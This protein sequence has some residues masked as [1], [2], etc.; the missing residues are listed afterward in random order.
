MF[1][2]MVSGTPSSGESGRP[3]RQRDSE[4]LRLLE[5]RVA[6]HAVHGV[7][8]R[9]PRVDSL[10]QRA[11]DL[12][13]R[14]LAARVGRGELRG[15]ALVNGGHCNSIYTRRRM[16]R[17][18]VLVLLVLCAA[19][20]RAADIRLWHSMNGTRG[21]EFDKLVARFNASQAQFRVVATYKG[22]FD[23]AAVEAVT[24]RGTR[25]FARRAPHIVQ[26]SEL[27]GAFLIEQKGVARPLWQVINLKS[28]ASFGEELVDAEGRLLALPLGRA[29]PVLYYNRDVFRIALL[30]PAKPPVTW[31]D[32]VPALA[33]LVAAG[34][35]CAL[36]MAWPASTLLENM[37]AWHNQAFATD[38]LMFNNRLAVRWVSTLA[39]WQKSGY[40]SYASRRGEAEARFAAGECAL[41]AA[42]S[43]SYDELRSRAG[44]DLGIAQLPYYDDFDSAPLNTLPSGA[45]LWVMAGRPAADYAGVA[46]FLAFFARPEV[47]AEWHQRTGLVPLSAAAYELTRKA[48]FYKKNPGHEVAVRQLLVRGTPNWKSLRLREHPH[49]HSIIDEELESAWQ[50]KKSPLDALNAA[51]VRGNAFLDSSGK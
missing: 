49:L 40:F 11:R 9:L 35:D 30:D 14:E 13:R 27:G 2:L 43:A 4:A 29:T 5:R 51:V 45:A 42:S 46:R 18:V 17:T 26:A 21:A 19:Q 10:E 36:T 50:G 37:A 6:M 8:A 22:S 47:Q 33:A 12:E 24:A 16:L 48:G 41:L 38:R 25:N 23:E 15:A 7:D 44:F 31:Y 20:L 1:S 3:A 39:S 34:S 28:E 32:M